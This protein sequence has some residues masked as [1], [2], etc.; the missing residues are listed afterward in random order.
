MAKGAWSEPRHSWHSR[1]KELVP[2]FVKVING[3]W[4]LKQDKWTTP[5]IEQS[6]MLCWD[7]TFRQC[8]ERIKTRKGMV[9]DIGAFIGDSTEWFSREGRDVIAF[10]PQRDAFT[11]LRHNIPN[12]QHFPFPVGDGE[13]VQLQFGEGGNMGARCLTTASEG[14]RTIRL[15]DL[16]IEGV[17]FIKIDVEGWEPAVLR[18]AS[19]TIKRCRPLVRI[20]YN[21]PA[22]DRYGSSYSD[23]EKHFSGWKWIEVFRN[24]NEHWDVLYIP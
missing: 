10:E 20:E 3:I 5:E 18:G 6:G 16:G 8:V 14:I 13:I 1:M 24:G 19:E 2:K 9:I 17:A 22:L 4:T 21:K 12:G 7:A 11:C 15:D 23:I